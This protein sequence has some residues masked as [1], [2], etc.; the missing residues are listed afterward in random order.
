MTGQVCVA[1]MSQ[2]TGLGVGGACIVSLCPCLPSV[3][4]AGAGGVPCECGQLSVRKS[5]Q[6]CV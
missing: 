3:P 4:L 2:C 5:P 1:Q 6:V